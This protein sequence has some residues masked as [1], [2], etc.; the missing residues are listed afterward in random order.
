MLYKNGISR[1]LIIEQKNHHSLLKNTAT[2]EYVVAYSLRTNDTKSTCE[3]ISGHY[4]M[5]LKEAV[6]YFYGEVMGWEN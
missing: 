1:F 5:D 4:F 3:W 6:D 2:S